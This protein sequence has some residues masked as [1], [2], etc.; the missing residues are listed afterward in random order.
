MP[1]S[2]SPQPPLLRL[3]GLSKT[4]GGKTVLTNVGFDV[5]AGEVHALAGQ[6]G[7]GKSTL[8]KILAGFHHPDPGGHIWKDG[9]EL[10]LPVRPREAASRG[11]CFLHQDL[12]LA[13]S[14][15]IAENILVG[16]GFD[17][18]AFWRIPWSR[19]YRI[20]QDLL[21]E[22]GVAARPRTPVSAISE[23][24]RAIIAILRA[25]EQFRALQ[26]RG[27]IVLDEPT[28]FL[29]RREVSRVF[30]AIRAAVQTGAGV[31][32]V[33]HRLDEVRAISD[34]ISVLRDGALVGTLNTS[35]AEE[36]DVVRLLLGRDLADLYPEPSGAPAAEVVLRVRN[37]SA[38]ELEDV[39]FDLHRGEIL[40]VTGLLGMGQDQLPYVLAGSQRPTG[41]SLD[42]NGSPVPGGNPRAAVQAGM[43]LLPAD[44]KTQS[45]LQSA[46]VGEN[47]SLP[48]VGRYWRGGRLRHQQESRDVA[49]L[50][51]EFSV[52]P[53]APGRTLSSL[54]GGNQQKALL[55]KWMQTK[56]SVLVLHEPT[57]GVDIG[58]RSQIFRRLQ[59]AVREGASILICSSEYE[60]LAHLCDRVLVLREGTVSRELTGNALTEDNILRALYVSSGAS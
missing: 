32:F 8:I 36:R 17:R 24:D 9:A 12:A 1:S 46:T 6:N 53:P 59:E 51:R 16:R 15:T 27:V 41:G 33:S 19:E 40:G 42:L 37:V 55:A 43:A 60:D 7:S 29:P 3:E 44:R 13:P 34:R 31:I 48:V 30:A 20:V 25:L 56:P 57:Q 52:T 50:L 2:G 54:S 5:M 38:G 49:A 26:G 23:I 39:G 21:D 28:A 58:A 45:S 22:Y 47:V 11:L 35:E 4:F 18:G 10:H 14:M